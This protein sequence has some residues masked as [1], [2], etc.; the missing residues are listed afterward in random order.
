MPECCEECKRKEESK[1]DCSYFKDC[2]RWRAWFSEEWQT[3]Q[4]NY[5]ELKLQKEERDGGR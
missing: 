1:P 2:L 5:R 3:I 4:R